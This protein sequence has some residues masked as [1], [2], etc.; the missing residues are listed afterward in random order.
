MDSELHGLSSLGDCLV[1]DVMQNVGLKVESQLCFF[2]TALV[3]EVQT[4]VDRTPR[5]EL[6]FF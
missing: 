6:S 4:V 3:S 5:L 1:A 2:R